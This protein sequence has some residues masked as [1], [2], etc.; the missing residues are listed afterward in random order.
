MFRR[1]AGSVWV[2]V[3]G[4]DEVVR[5]DPDTNKIVRRISVDAGPCGTARA[6]SG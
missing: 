6:P 2:T 5:I 3:F 1:E 4:T